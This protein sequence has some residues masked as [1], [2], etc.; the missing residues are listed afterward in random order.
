MLLKIIYLVNAF[1]RVA[2]ENHNAVNNY[3][4]SHTGCPCF[5]DENRKGRIKKSVQIH[6]H[7]SKPE[8]P[9]RKEVCDR[10][11]A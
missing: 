7:Y 2:A 11:Q 3:T 4:I 10:M 6:H 8:S 9:L 1:Q 5:Y